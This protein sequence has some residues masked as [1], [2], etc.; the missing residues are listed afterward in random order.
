VQAYRIAPGDVV[1]VVVWGQERF[2]QECQVNGVGT[3]TYSVLGEVKAAGLTL[4]ELQSSLE[5]GLRKYLKQPQVSVTVRQYGALGTSVFV[6]GEVRSPGAYPLVSS[7]GLVQA[8]AAAGGP[9]AKASEQITIAKARTGELLTVGL[10]EAV[11]AG[12]S[13]SGVSVEPGDVVIVNR[14]PE[15]DQ[16]RRYSV[17]GE[18][19]TPGIFDMPAD[20]DAHVL[21]AMQKAGL[22][23]ANG[24]AGGPAEGSGSVLDQRSRLAD[25]EH[26]VLLRGEEVVPLDLAALLQ[27]DVSQDL[28]LQPGDVI[29]VP[30]RQL[31]TVYATGEVRSAGR[32]F[33]P[34]DSTVLDLLNAAQGVTQGANLGGAAVLRLVEGK[35]TPVSVDLG[36][37]LGRAEMKQNAKLQDGDVLFVPARGESNQQ[38]FLRWLTLIAYWVR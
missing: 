37:L 11:S 15:A 8:L 34:V 1:S 17:L 3:I 30:R 33:M 36:A 25:L 10:V 27:G 28:L 6:L 2:S 22:L 13:S 4:T 21:D 38:T 9:T 20:G 18:V 24:S 19:P 14:K 23:E 12:L 35:P 26:A 16:D 5:S 32:Y 31:V 29:T 7:A